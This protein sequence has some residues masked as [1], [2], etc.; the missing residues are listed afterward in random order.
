[1]KLLLIISSLGSGGAERVSTSLANEWADA[2]HSVI[3]FTLSDSP[4]F[5]TLHPAVCHEAAGLFR[6]SDNIWDAVSAN[7]QRMTAIRRAIARFS[8]DVIVSFMDR[9]NV[10]SILSNLGTRLPIIACEHTDTKQL[11]I[12]KLWSALRLLTYPFASAITFLTENVRQRWARAL[13]GKAVLMPNP[14][15]LSKDNQETL[16]SGALGHKRNLM[17]VGRLAEEKGLDNLFRAFASIAARHGDWGLTIL[18]EGNKRDE[19][20]KLRAE[21]GL[22]G[23]VHLPGCVKNPFTWLRRADLFVMSSRLEGLPCSLCEAMGCGLPAISFDCDSGPRDI[24]RDGVDGLLVPPG[25]V[26]GLS[27]AMDRLMS[28]DGERAQFAARAPEVMDRYNVKSIL[29]RWDE[30]FERVRPTRKSNIRVHECE[31]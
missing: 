1:M 3:I 5:Y 15:H 22:E 26:P 9:M 28:D 4:S 7:L 20:E 14:V 6:E 21:L 11:S 17:A 2:G 23:R 10:L 24:I 30:L 29:L 19:L 27:R 25:D 18:G 8:P 31:E 16:P 12:G 13:N